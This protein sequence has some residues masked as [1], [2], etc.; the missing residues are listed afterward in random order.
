V[1]AGGHGMPGK[2]QCG[3]QIFGAVIDPWQKMAVKV[4]HARLEEYPLL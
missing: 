1:D 2:L 3:G 4:D